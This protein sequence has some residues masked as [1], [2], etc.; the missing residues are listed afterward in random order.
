MDKYVNRIL[1]VL[2]NSVRLP[3]LGRAIDQ[4]GL[5]YGK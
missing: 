1:D 5:E 2:M 3:L 4:F